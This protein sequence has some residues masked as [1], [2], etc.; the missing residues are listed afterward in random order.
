MIINA[1]CS[2]CNNHTN[3]VF[4]SLV[5]WFITT[6]RLKESV[7]KAGSRLQNVA[8]NLLKQS[9]KASIYS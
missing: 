8:V 4:A 6:I 3:S 5:D 9:T 1:D 7:R 2:N